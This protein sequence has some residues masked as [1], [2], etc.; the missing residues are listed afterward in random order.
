MWMKK[1]KIT[2]MNT[3]KK[4]EAGTSTNLSGGL[5]KGF[6]VVRER[7]NPQEV[8]S[9]ILFTDGLANVGLTKTQDI[10]LGMENEIKKTW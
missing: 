1:G 6:E 3:V 9:I 8:A 4:L 10:V 7:K 2:I 5:F